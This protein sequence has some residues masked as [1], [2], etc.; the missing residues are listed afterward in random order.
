[1][2]LL[3]AG[4]IPLATQ[5]QMG[6]CPE[7]NVWRGVDGRDRS[8]AAGTGIRRRY[9]LRVRQT[10]LVYG[11]EWERFKLE[12]RDSDVVSVNSGHYYRR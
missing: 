7:R 8:A 12:P 6:L 3:L 1:M 9:R 10:G 5:P 2:G 4:A 11:F